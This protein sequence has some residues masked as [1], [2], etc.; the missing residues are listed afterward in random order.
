MHLQVPSSVELAPPPWV[1]AL[2]PD[3]RSFV[4]LF[5][6]PVAMGARARRIEL[7]EMSGAC[8]RRVKTGRCRHTA[9]GRDARRCA[10]ADR[11][12]ARRAAVVSS[13]HR[14]RTTHGW[15]CVC[16]CVRAHLAATW[17]ALRRAMHLGMRGATCCT[18]LL[19][20]WGALQHDS[21]V[22]VLGSSETKKTEVVTTPPRFSFGFR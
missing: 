13:G 18:H 20:F 3:R 21:Q 14:E 7:C 2:G 4:G 1:G 8:S 12:T 16:V 17:C 9:K 6:A 10:R 11:D 15:A 5:A 22:S 19:G